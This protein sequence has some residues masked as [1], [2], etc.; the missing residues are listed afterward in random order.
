MQNRKISLIITV[1]FF[2]LLVLAYTPHS[3]L[4]QPGCCPHSMY[5][6]YLNTSHNSTLTTV[7]SPV[8]I[9]STT[10]LGGVMAF[11]M[12]A[13]SNLSAATFGGWYV[14]QVW[15]QKAGNHYDIFFAA[16]TNGGQNYS[17]IINL[18]NSSTNS[19]QPH[20]G[21]FGEDVFV[22]WTGKVNS[23]SQTDIFYKKSTDAGLTFGPVINLSNSPS[24]DSVDSSLLV[25]QNTGKIVVDWIEAPLPATAHAAATP[26]QILTTCVTR[27]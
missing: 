17:K 25:D 23:T 18:S 4:S 12:A 15:Q 13:A 6:P 3:A 1:L 26:I 20:V 27:C 16:S 2:A 21:A 14:Y 10:S 8:P 19:T 5:N 11:T 22:I 24:T 9:L 7:P